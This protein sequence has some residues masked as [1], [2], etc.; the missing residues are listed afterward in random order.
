MEIKGYPEEPFKEA[1]DQMEIESPFDRED[2]F[3]HISYFAD[4]CYKSC[5]DQNLNFGT[6]MEAY[7]NWRAI[8]SEKYFKVYFSYIHSEDIIVVVNGY[9]ELTK[10]DYVEAFGSITDEDCNCN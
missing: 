3:H 10:E 4:V 6:E 8:E 7:F 5:N 2:F 1:L 9:E